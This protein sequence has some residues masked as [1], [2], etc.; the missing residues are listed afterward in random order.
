MSQEDYNT[1][2]SVLSE[3]LA[4]TADET[5][6]TLPVPTAT[7]STVSADTKVQLQPGNC[8]LLNQL[9]HSVYLFISKS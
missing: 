4:E 2:M 9:I 8:L 6:S 1:I 5:Q 3:N 7:V